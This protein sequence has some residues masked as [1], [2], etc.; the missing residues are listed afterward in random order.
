MVG[1]KAIP[2]SSITVLTAPVV[3]LDDI[4]SSPVNTITAVANGTPLDTGTPVMLLSAAVDGGMGSYTIN[5][6][7]AELAIRAD[8][9]ART[10]KADATYALVTGP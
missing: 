6:M 1:G 4:T 9:Y 2:A 3:N 7:I 8:A 5:N 10:Y